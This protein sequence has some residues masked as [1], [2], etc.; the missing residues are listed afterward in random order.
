LIEDVAGHWRSVMLT[1]TT[2]SYVDDRPADLNGL[3]LLATGNRQT[4]DGWM[5]Q[6]R[7]VLGLDTRDRLP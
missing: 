4:W 5:R 7:A 6:N 2:R 3:A 1:V